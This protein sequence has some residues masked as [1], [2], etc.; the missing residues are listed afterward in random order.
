MIS[1]RI[2]NRMMDILPDTH[3]QRQRIARAI[4]ESPKWQF[5]DISYAVGVPAV[6]VGNGKTG[7]DKAAYVVSREGCMCP[8]YTERVHP[9]NDSH[10][11][12]CKHQIG[13]AIHGHLASVMPVPTQNPKPELGDADAPP[14]RRT[15]K[16]STQPE[17]ETATVA[18][19]DTD[20]A[21]AEKRAAAARDRDALWPRDEFDR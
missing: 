21:A 17:T 18:V 6:I 2:L 5:L 9:A 10:L 13:A 8:D 11:R 3:D 14:A 4:D 12:M 1:E 16:Q 20:T 7:K 15:R 19:A